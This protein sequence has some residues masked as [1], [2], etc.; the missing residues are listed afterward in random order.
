MERDSPKRPTLGSLIPIAT[1]LVALIGAVAYG[2][3]R[4]SYQQF[5]DRFGLTPD[6][7]GP[8]SAAALTQS[9]IRVATFVA[10]F[11]LLPAVLALAVSQGLAKLL[12]PGFARLRR[13]AP[14]LKNRLLIVA[15]VLLPVVP[16]LVVYR[17][18][19]VVTSGSREL[20]EQ[21]VLALAVLLLTSK[22]YG[23]PLPT[24]RLPS[25]GWIVGITLGVCGA[26][27]LGGSLPRDA[28]KTAGCVID[29]RRPVRWVHTHRTFLGI[30]S[31]SHIAVLQ[32][33][34]DPAQM[35]WRTSPASPHAKH[36]FLPVRTREVK[37][38]PV[39]LV[40]VPSG[41]H[42]VGMVY[43][44]ASVIFGLIAGG[45]GLLVVCAAGIL[46]AWRGW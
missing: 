31:L 5:Y 28:K 4:Y 38:S 19:T 15:Y 40:P 41:E 33:R 9:G 13:S 44:P 25:N 26:L 16:A 22:R 36:A 39:R 8:S 46:A 6:D 23:E 20:N 14:R 27:V 42:T 34:A 35:H 2:I 17:L 24:R 11:A 45:L 12:Q 10:L 30:K 3:M 1:G 21:I 7:A 18:F 29:H 37:Q 43:R 32:A